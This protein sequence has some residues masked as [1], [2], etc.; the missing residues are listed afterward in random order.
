M[1][2]FSSGKY[3]ELIYFSLGT[4]IIPILGPLGCS[5]DH[6]CF[7]FTFFFSSLCFTFY[8]ALFSCLQVFISLLLLMYFLPLSPPN[9]FFISDTVVFILRNLIWLFKNIFHFHTLQWQ[10]FSPRLN[11]RQAPWAFF[12]TMPP[13][14][15]IKTA[16]SQHKLLCP[17]PLTLPHA[18]TWKDM[19]KF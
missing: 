1:F 16:D 8:I 19:K 6:L 4:Q 5:A 15:P 9:I 14:R 3:P 11:S 13:P 12:S 10:W 18:R 7:I 17:Y 2:S